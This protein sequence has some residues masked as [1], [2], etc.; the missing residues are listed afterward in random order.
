MA[1]CSASHSVE[2][3]VWMKVVWT[4]KCLAEL[5]AGQSGGLTDGELV[6]PLGHWKVGLKVERWAEPM[7]YLTVACSAAMLDL[8][9]AGAFVAENLLIIL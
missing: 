8:G 2:L 4:D 6:A 9:L 3:M 1:D 7:A 5:M